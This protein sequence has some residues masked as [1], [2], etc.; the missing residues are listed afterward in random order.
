MNAKRVAILVDNYFEQSEFEEP[1]EALRDAG[2][3]VTV[4][5]ARSKDLQALI[6]VDK[7]DTFE[8]DT[9]LSDVTTDEFDALVLPGGAMNAD[10]LRMIE[11]A[12]QWVRDFLDS[13]K[14]VAAICHAP[15]LLVSAD[16]VQ[17]RKLTSYFTIQDDIDN[18]G[19]EWVDQPVVIDYTLIT[20]RKPDD[21]PAFNDA[22]LTTLRADAIDGVEEV[23]DKQDG[24]Q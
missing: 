21:L 18:A 11:P 3:E 9:V 8:A 10:Q 13:G 5:G 17:G 4:V 7:G 22:I 20:S 14:L 16:E 2:F 12:R 1:L 19:G 24:T 15:W 23:K 6:H